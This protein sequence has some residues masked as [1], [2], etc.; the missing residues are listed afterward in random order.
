MK[1]NSE[2]DNDNH[3]CFPYHHTYPHELNNLPSTSI[4]APSS[5]LP[6]V[7]KSTLQLK[8]LPLE[9]PL[10]R[11]IQGSIGQPQWYRSSPYRIHFIQLQ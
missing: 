11:S 6:L 9:V 1:N 8:N 2:G 5:N 10:N 7:E 3:D 4:S